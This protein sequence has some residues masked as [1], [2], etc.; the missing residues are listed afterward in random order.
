MLKL[1]LPFEETK[2][3]ISDMMVYLE[4]HNDCLKG[5]DGATVDNES[6][7]ANLANLAVSAHQC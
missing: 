4:N 1:K 7:S 5:A 3:S 2:M 6:E